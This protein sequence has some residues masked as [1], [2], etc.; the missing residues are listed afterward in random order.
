MSKLDYCNSLLY[1]TSQKNFDKLQRVQNALA[2]TVTRSSRRTHMRPVL[3]KLH[4]LPVRVRTRFKMA[5]LAYKSRIGLLPRYLSDTLVDYKPVRTLRS[6]AGAPLFQIRRV[7]NEMT[8]RSFGFAAADV[9][10]ALPADLKLAPSLA[11]FKAKLKTFLFQE[12]YEL[13]L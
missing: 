6:G 5:V 1:E 8:K 9:W 11:I 7:R 4:W 13:L 3:A 12:A 2:R 10:N